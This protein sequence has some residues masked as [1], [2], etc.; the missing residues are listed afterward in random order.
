VSAL[1]L[2]GCFASPLLRPVTPPAMSSSDDAGFAFAVH[3]TTEHALTFLARTPL[4]F[5]DSQWLE[6]HLRLLRAE[7]ARVLALFDHKAPE[8]VETL[9]RSGRFPAD[10]GPIR[11]AIWGVPMA[12]PRDAAGL[13]QRRRELLSNALASP[14]LGVREQMAYNEMDLGATRS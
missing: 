7:P 4:A 9:E 14:T 8:V 5:M 12:G 6:T 13:V 1:E 11:C 3:R 2:R 10:G